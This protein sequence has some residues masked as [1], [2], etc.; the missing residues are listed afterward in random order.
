MQDHCVKWGSRFDFT[1]KMTANASSGILDS[2]I[3][4]ISVRKVSTLFKSGLYLEV[5]SSQE[6]TDYSLPF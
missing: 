1:C 6:L 2:C 3:M 4:R 5:R